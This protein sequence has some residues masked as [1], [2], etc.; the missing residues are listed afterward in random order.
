MDTVHNFG[1]K[2]E[3]F[4]NTVHNFCKKCK[5]SVIL[6]TISVN[7]SNAHGYCTHF[8]QKT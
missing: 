7:N 4:R 2:M 5:R 6:Y 1:K 3:M 8:L